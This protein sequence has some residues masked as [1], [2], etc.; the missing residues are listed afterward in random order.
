MTSLWNLGL[1]RTGEKTVEKQSSAVVR[2]SAPQDKSSNE[3]LKQLTPQLFN[4]GTV[5][6][7]DRLYEVFRAIIPI[8]ITDIGI[9]IWIKHRMIQSQSHLVLFV[10]S[11]YAPFLMCGGWSQ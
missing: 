10:E 11:E 3:L 7:C 6:E 4:G 8:A 5:P 9:I 2:E 1:G